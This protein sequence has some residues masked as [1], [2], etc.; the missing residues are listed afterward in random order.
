MGEDP[1]TSDGH[2]L[3]LHLS[4]NYRLLISEDLNTIPDGEAIEDGPD[5]SIHPLQGIEQTNIY[6]EIKLELNCWGQETFY[7]FSNGETGYDYDLS[8]YPE[9]GGY[10]WM[11]TDA[12]CEAYIETDID[13][14]L[15]FEPS[16]QSLIWKGKKYITISRD[17][18]FY[19]HTINGTNDPL[20]KEFYNGP[21]NKVMETRQGWGMDL[22]KVEVYKQWGEN[23]T[24]P[25]IINVKPGSK[26][27]YRILSPTSDGTAGGAVYP[28]SHHLSGIVSGINSYYNQYS[29]FG[30]RMINNMCYGPLDEDGCYG[31]LGQNSNL[32]NLLSNPH[33]YYYLDNANNR[34][35]FTNKF[36]GIVYNRHKV[37]GKIYG[38]PILKVN[39]KYCVFLETYRVRAT[40]FHYD[41]NVFINL[42][43]GNIF[44]VKNKDL[45]NK[46]TGYVRN[47]DDL[48]NWLPRGNNPQ[49]LNNPTLYYPGLQAY[50]INFKHTDLDGN[51]SFAFQHDFGD[52]T[53]YS[54]GNLNK[55]GGQI[56]DN[57]FNPKDGGSNNQYILKTIIK[58]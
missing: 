15:T 47:S 2:S 17:P 46:V 27:A 14:T 12:S 26:I 53:S 33:N 6:S 45:D 52:D 34:K 18:K 54:G 3:T 11:D 39:G 9:T 1:Y 30:T 10:W 43:N 48:F 56:K 5:F 42:H 13:P 7:K 58:S 28:G 19:G 50:S 20:D 25:A 51:T 8:G 55:V 16:G 41:Y 29:D 44:R 22:P 31:K 38:Q 49:Y 21:Y 57:P 35:T 36:L 4:P 24:F 37:R 32:N 23:S 40:A